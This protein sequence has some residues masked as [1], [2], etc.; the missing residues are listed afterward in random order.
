MSD[1]RNGEDSV[2]V[3]AISES[4]SIFEQV[5]NLMSAEITVGE[6]RELRDEVGRLQMEIVRL[7]TEQGEDL[8][9][10]DRLRLLITAWADAQEKRISDGGFDPKKIKWSETDTALRKAIGR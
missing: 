7:S 4:I 9:L 1:E 5:E 6:V 8:M 10:I 3:P 2:L